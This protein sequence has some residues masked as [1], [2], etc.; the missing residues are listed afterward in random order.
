MDFI[1]SN[2]IAQ[3]YANGVQTSC[4]NWTVTL[5]YYS[6]TFSQV[7]A[8]VDVKNNICLGDVAIQRN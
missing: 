2:L 5:S 8:S 7:E 3:T 6:G 1:A 4:Y